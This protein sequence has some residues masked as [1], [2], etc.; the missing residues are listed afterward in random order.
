MAATTDITTAAA[1][2]A[3]ERTR[4]ALT[5]PLLVYED[6]GWAAD[7]EGLA[8]VYSA[9]G[10]EHRVD[11]VKGACD[12]DDQYYR[13][14]EHA[15]KHARRAAIAL[16]YLPVPAWVDHPEQLDDYLHRDL[17]AED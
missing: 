15:C 4:R 13:D 9:D 14:P 5:E 7:T 11:V 17:E 3:D 8:L 2:P 16:G 12:C 10:T 6:L 1:L